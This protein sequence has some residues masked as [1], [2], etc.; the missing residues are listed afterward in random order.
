M[1]RF[2]IEIVIVALCVVFLILGW[3]I[4]GAG[5]MGR[6]A[7]AI[8][9]Q[10]APSELYARLTIHYAKP[11]VD[12]EEYRT[13]DVE[14][15]SSF[16]YSIRGYDGRQITVN[17]PPARVY[18]VSFFFGRLVQDGVW[19]LVDKPSLP[20]ANAHYT[21]WVKQLADYQHGQRT[22]TFTDPQYWATKSGREY[23]IDL[24]KGVPRDLLHVSSTEVADPR[25][26]QIV[27]DFRD[28]GPD[29]FRHNV[30]AAQERIRGPH[31]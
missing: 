16:Q 15:V 8:H 29:V 30:A 22:V 10:K 1:R 26:D 21:V 9:A 18:D 5:E 14:G 7:P 11:P 13:S 19:D 28:F 31:G 27:K 2:P 3:R 17:A 20:N 24:S 12:T 25:Y 23:S 6:F 4:Y